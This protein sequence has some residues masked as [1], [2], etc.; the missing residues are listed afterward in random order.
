MSQLF[1]EQ[2]QRV[3]KSGAKVSRALNGI[4]LALGWQLCRRLVPV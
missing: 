4:I 3:Y 1:E 2:Y